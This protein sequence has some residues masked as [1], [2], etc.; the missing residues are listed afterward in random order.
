MTKKIGLPF[1]KTGENSFGS[2]IPYIAY[3][4]RFGEVVPLMPEHTVREDLDL[5]ILPGG[6]DV[7]PLNYGETPGYYTGK[8]DMFKEHFDRKYLQQYID[9]GVPI[10][11]ICR[12]HQA[13]AVHL[14][15]KLIQHM[16][17]ETTNVSVD[18]TKIVHDM[19]F[20][21][22]FTT[23]HEF[24]PTT[25]TGVNSRHHQVVA[26]DT[27]PDELVIIARHKSFTKANQK[28]Y[29]TDNTIEMM[30]HR[31]LPIVTLQSHAEDTYDK[32][33]QQ[34]LDNVILH[35]INTKTAIL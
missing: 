29:Y 22:E 13:L 27:L 7:N 30:A 32:M 9:A 5:L 24:T 10:F 20:T 2:T 12:G 31:E 23:R 8:P 15:A 11:A 6:P 34:F 26:E 19:V 1:W 3:A 25:F 28:Q 35:L 17:H 21:P 18:P 14:G 4:G 33:T 16:N